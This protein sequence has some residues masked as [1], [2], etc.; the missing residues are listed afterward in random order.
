MLIH[1]ITAER[2]ITIFSFLSYLTAHSDRRSVGLSVL[3]SGTPLGPMTRFSFSFPLPDNCF[4]LRLGAPSL[5]RG[6][7]CNL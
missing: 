5:T 2:R 4:A 3:V 7:V 6:R 1:P